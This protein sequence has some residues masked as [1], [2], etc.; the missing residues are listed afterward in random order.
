M[1]PDMVCFNLIYDSSLHNR[2]IWRTYFSNKHRLEIQC[3]SYLLA[4]ISFLFLLTFIST[5][6]DAHIKKQA[7][8]FMLAFI[9][10]FL[11]SLYMF[12]RNY[13]KCCTVFKRYKNTNLTVYDDKI[14]CFVR[15]RNKLLPVLTHPFTVDLYTINISDIKS[16][17]VQN[18]VCRIT[19]YFV[20]QKIIFGKCKRA[21]RIDTTLIIPLDMKREVRPIL[22]EYD[23]KGN[24]CN[25]IW[26]D[27]Q[28]ASPPAD[29]LILQWYKIIRTIHK[30]HT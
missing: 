9:A 25:V 23:Y 22:I 15:L 28:A 20:F 8:I 24:I 2:L 30:I 29:S 10:F 6:N 12:I 4:I 16:I 1:I 13:F 3:D 21:K 7:I 17:D 18:N 14:E 27:K 26:P 19:G 11:L 5:F